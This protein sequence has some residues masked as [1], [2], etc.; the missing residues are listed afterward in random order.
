MKGKEKGK[1]NPQGHTDEQDSSGVQLVKS[2]LSEIFHTQLSKSGPAGINFALSGKLDWTMSRGPAPSIFF[3]C[4]LI[5]A[6]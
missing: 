5:I 6:N 4:V 2:P 3:H 1:G